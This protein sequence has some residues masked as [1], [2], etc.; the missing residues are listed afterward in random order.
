MLVGFR[1]RF[2]VKERFFLIL[3]QKFP[4]PQRA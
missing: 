3:G 2:L 4:G 1:K